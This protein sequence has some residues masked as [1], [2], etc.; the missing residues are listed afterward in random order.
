MQTMLEKLTGGKFLVVGRAGMDLSPI[1]AGT[2][3]EDATQMS[4]HLGG[5]SANI[6]AALTRHGCEADLVTCVSDDAIGRFCLN[7]LDHYKIGRDH[8]RSIGGEYR[9][10]LAVT[11]SRIEDHQTVIYR[12]GAADFQMDKSDIDKVDFS[13]FDAMIVTGTLFASEPSR[14]ASLYALEKAKAAG[15]ICILDVDYRPYS[16][17]SDKQ[18]TEIYSQIGPLCDIVIGNDDEFGFM[19]GSKDAGQAFAKDLAQRINGICVYKMGPEG[20]ITYADGCSFQTGIFKVDALKPTG[21]GDAFMGGFLATLV[22]KGDLQEAVLRGSA[23]AAIVVSKPGCA[24]AMPTPDELN[25]F[26]N[27]NHV[28]SQTA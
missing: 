8:V 6:A 18:A 16:W 22:K 9:N 4:A 14:T 20:S 1:P 2:K 24:P 28:T 17:E 5:S 7:Q 15:V 25:A 23:S 10:T 12:N 11:E 13:R 21:A 26:L 19:A 27:S 3:A